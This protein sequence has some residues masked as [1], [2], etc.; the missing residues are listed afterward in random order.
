MAKPKSFEEFYYSKTGRTCNVKD[1]VDYSKKNHGNYT[2]FEGAMFCPECEKAELFLV[3]ETSGK[4][5]H[6]KKKPSSSHDDT[7]S[8]IYEYASKTTIQNYV[9]GLTNGQIQD[10]L[11]SIM[12]MLFKV[13]N[14]KSNILIK[15][16]ISNS[17]NNSSPMLIPEVKKDVIELKSLRRKSLSSWID[18]SDG[19]NLYLF[20]GEVK[21]EVVEK[22]KV[23]DGGE[24]YKYYLLKLWTLNKLGQWKYRTQIYRGGNKDVVD[25]NKVHRVAMIGNL[26]FKWKR[27]QIDLINQSAIR[28][29]HMKIM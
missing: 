16:N 27:W 4:R 18:E 13:K 26:N 3:R 15:N 29:E 10:K 6:L 21:L 7:C 11:N 1:V 17:K 12:H 28:I 22:E 2:P 20:Y 23:N 14:Q 5:A 19:T 25:I 24:S 8:Y 9:K